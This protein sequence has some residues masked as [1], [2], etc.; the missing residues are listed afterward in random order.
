MPNGLTAQT[1]ANPVKVCIPAVEILM[2][3]G[4]LCMVTMIRPALTI[5]N[6]RIYLQYLNCNT[7]IGIF[8]LFSN[9]NPRAGMKI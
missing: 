2:R 8:K 6:N 1:E 7:K 9:W 3:Y 4:Y 5:A